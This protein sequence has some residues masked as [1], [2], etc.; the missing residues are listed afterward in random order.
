MTWLELT[1]FLAGF[2]P[3]LG[4]GVGLTAMALLP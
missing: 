2:I 4:I 3:G 1:I